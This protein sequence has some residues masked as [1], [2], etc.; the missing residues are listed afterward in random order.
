MCGDVG[1][2]WNGG[3]SRLKD[4]WKKLKVRGCK[5]DGRGRMMGM[6]HEAWAWLW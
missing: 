5:M 1:Q 2:G 3:G 6:E 4:S